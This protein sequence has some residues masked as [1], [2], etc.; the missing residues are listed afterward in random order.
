VGVRAVEL[1]ELHARLS[2]LW[3]ERLWETSPSEPDQRAQRLRDCR[4]ALERMR[5]AIELCPDDAPI[6]RSFLRARLCT[7]LSARYGLDQPELL[8]EAVRALEKDPVIIAGLEE[9]NGSHPSTVTNIAFVSYYAAYACL[10]VEP[11]RLGECRRFLERARRYKTF[12]ARGDNIETLR[13]IDGFVRS[14]L[15]KREQ[16]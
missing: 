8:L 14:A 9:P 7:I 10:E 11:P 4:P 16:R 15:E 5:R 3:N 6:Q 12:E 2:L 1:L 13:E